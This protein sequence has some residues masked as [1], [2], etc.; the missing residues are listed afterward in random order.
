M[1][2]RLVSFLRERMPRCYAG[3]CSFYWGARAVLA[4]LQGTA[5]QEKRW[6]TRHE[7]MGNEWGGDSPVGNEKKWIQSYWASRNHPHRALLVEK[8]AAYSPLREILELGCNCG[9]N[10]YWIAKK[11]RPARMVGVDINAMAIQEGIALLHSEGIFNAELRVGSARA[12]GEFPDRSFDLVFTDAVLIYVAPDKIEEVIR[13]MLRI[14]RK[15]LVL[16]EWHLE[17]KEEDPSGSGIYHKGCWK[18]NY[19]NL[20]SRFIPRD[21]VRAAKLPQQAWPEKNWRELGYII[22][23]LL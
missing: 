17:R 12:M 23:A 3:A 22:E 6:S 13:E 8:I 10:L 4:R 19:V 1:L 15:A 18:R 5:A 11:I 21:R 20:L 7:R 9:P 14:S 16:L 2:A